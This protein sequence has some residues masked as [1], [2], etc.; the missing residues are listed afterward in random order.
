MST[1]LADN[2]ARE[3]VEQTLDMYREFR[4]RKGG[5]PLQTETRSY[6]FVVEH[7]QEFKGTRWTSFRGRG[8]RKQMQGYCFANA[9]EM[10]M[11]RP[12]LT[13]FEGYAYGG[14]IPAHHAWCVDELGRVVDPTWRKDKRRELD[15][16]E[17]DYFGVG[18]D[19]HAL[20]DWWIT[21][22]SASVLA[23]MVRNPDVLDFVV[24]V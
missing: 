12:E 11:E 16:E 20:A 9:W 2:Y 10:S 4:A 8:Y 13:Y 21:R 6:E 3:Y 1:T 24:R 7:G 14:L 23:E 22:D 15:E 19:S 18:F 5:R 17:W